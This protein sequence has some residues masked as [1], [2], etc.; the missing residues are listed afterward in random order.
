MP[1]GKLVAYSELGRLVGADQPAVQED[2]LV[3]ESHRGHRL[4]ML[5]KA[6]NAQFMLEH[7]PDTALVTTFNAEENEPMLRVNIELGFKPICAE[8]ELQKRV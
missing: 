7:A 3:L 1:T 8:G 2:T 5:L 6:A 4:G